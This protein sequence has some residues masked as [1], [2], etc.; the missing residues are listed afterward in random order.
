MKI[1]I[2]YAYYDKDIHN[3]PS[4]QQ[5]LKPEIILKEIG[6]LLIEKL[7][8]QGFEVVNC[9][10]T[11]SKNQND[12]INST[13]EIGN[14][15]KLDLFLSITLSS[16]STPSKY[17]N[18]I[19]INSDSGLNYETAKKIQ[20]RLQTLGYTSRGIVKNSAA[21]LIRDMNCPSLLIKCFYVTNSLECK[22]YNKDLI[23]NAIFRSLTSKDN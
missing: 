22:R 21:P 19:L 13:L 14:N 1:G 2:D 11:E 6:E 4:S 15:S 16:F 8:H 17:G 23:V 20:N 18:E 10:P 12:M 5:F 9:S 7:E 3:V